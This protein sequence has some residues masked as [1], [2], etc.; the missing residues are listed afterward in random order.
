M[1]NLPIL[2][3]SE[4]INFLELR[5]ASIDGY[6]TF[7]IVNWDYSN[8]KCDRIAYW[9]LVD[10]YNFIMCDN[11]F[12]KTDSISLNKFMY[13]GQKMLDCYLGEWERLVEM[14]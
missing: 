12:L 14:I 4:R 6:K 3:Y 9:E 8:E 13:K 7:E 1:K 2:E 11:K 10:Y 5:V